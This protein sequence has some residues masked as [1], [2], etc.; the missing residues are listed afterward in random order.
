MWGIATG[1]CVSEWCHVKHVIR[2]MEGRG[3]AFG[4]VCCWTLSALTQTV[5]RS[6]QWKTC[7]CAKATDD[8]MS[9]FLFFFFFFSVAFTLW[10][11]SQMQMPYFHPIFNHSSSFPLLQDIDTF[12]W[13]EWQRHPFLS[14]SP[15]MTSM[16]RWAYNYTDSCTVLN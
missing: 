14:I 11:F 10:M 8:T 6:H 16:G 4:H 12:I 3:A 15:C 13:K 5:T 9:F 2:V 1:S 7:Y